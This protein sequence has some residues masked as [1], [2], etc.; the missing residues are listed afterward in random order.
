M[1]LVLIVFGCSPSSPDL[2]TLQRDPAAAVRMTGAT[3]LG[4]FSGDRA[5]TLDGPLFAHD[6]RVFGVNETAAAVRIFYDREL[7]RLGLAARS[8]GDGDGHGRTCGVGLVQGGDGVSHWHSRSSVQARVLQR[9]N[10]RDRLRC[11][12]HGTRSVGGLPDTGSALAFP[13][14]IR[15]C[16]YG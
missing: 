2:R 1:L 11:R 15:G 4:H 9:T 12:P 14:R 6:D 16:H 5:S 7:Q 13:P 8:A 3:E 10:V